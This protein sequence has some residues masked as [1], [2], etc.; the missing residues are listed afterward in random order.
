MYILFLYEFVTQYEAKR[1][2]THKAIRGCRGCDHMVVEF[3]TTYAV[4]TFHH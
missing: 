1:V 3:T 4:S 2:K